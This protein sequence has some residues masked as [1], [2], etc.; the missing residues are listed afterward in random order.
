MTIIR[1]CFNRKNSNKTIY[2]VVFY[3][4]YLHRDQNNEL[5]RYNL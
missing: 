3:K 4:R 1:I 5:L 2:S